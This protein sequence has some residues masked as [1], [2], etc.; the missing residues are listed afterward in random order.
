MAKYSIFNQTVPKAGTNEDFHY[1]FPLVNVYKRK[2]IR[3]RELNLRQN[4][5]SGQNVSFSI[6][7]LALM[8]SLIFV[9]QGLFVLNNKWFLSLLVLIKPTNKYMLK[10]NSKHERKV[11]NLIIVS[12]KE[13]V[14]AVILVSLLLT[15]NIFHIFF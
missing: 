12:N 10:V 15:L 8:P 1:E 13:N 5:S 4:S 6:Y 7:D 9:P 3:T 14:I 11:W 2:K